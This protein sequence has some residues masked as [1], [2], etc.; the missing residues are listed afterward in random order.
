MAGATF[1][2]SNLSAFGIEQFT[3]IINPPGSAILAVGQIARQPAVD[4]HGALG[5]QSVMKAT[6]SCDHRVIDGAV[7]GGVPEGPQG[8]AGIPRGT[9]AVKM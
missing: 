8:H 4:S 7:A 9:A 6:L 2:I 1:T 3:A 5:I